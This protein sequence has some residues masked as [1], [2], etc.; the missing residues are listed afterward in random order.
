MT[1][2]KGSV[3]QRGRLDS[4]TREPNL[5]HFQ[6]ALDLVAFPFRTATPLQ[7]GRYVPVC[8]PRIEQRSIVPIA[9]A[10]VDSVATT[11]SLLHILKTSSSDQLGRVLLRLCVR[12]GL[13]SK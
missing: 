6:S 1:A 4:D 10:V 9:L 8:S 7:R 3:G 13:L 2:L 5:R 11:I 12:S